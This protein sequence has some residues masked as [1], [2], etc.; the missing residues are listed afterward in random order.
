MPNRLSQEEPGRR[1]DLH[2]TYFGSVER[3]ERN[4]TVTTLLAL[5]KDLDVPVSRL[6]KPLD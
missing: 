5:A 4:P 3:G 6:V 1:S 2:R